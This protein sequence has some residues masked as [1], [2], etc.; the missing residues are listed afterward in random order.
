MRLRETLVIY[1]FPLLVLPTVLFG[2]LS[3]YYSS[4]TFNQQAYIKVARHLGNQQ[5]KLEHFFNYQQQSL[6]TLA[7][8]QA[9]QQFIADA[10]PVAS[11]MATG[12][13]G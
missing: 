3:Y 5:Q 7:K 9:L 10:S 1:M 11:A 4:T 13:G 12:G 8:Q 2:Y 6:T